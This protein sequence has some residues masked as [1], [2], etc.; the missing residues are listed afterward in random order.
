MLKYKD[1]ILG[2][3]IVFLFLLSSVLVIVKSP[4]A[5]ATNPEWLGPAIGLLS[6]NGPIAASS[7]NPAFGPDGSEAILAELDALATDPRVKAIVLRINSPGGTVGASQEL[8]ESVTAIRSTLKKPVIV[9]IADMGTSGAYW[10]SMAGS[11][12][13]ANPGSVVGS[14]GVIMQSMDFTEVPRRY[15]INNITYKSGKYKDMLSSWRPASTDEKKLI[16]S[17]LDDIHDQFI[18]TLIQRRGLSTA[19]AMVIAQG[20]VF[21]GRQALQ[22][23]LI[24]YVGSIDFAIALAAKEVGIKGKPPI[25]SKA[26][27][28]FGSFLTKLLQLTSMVNPLMT[29]PRVPQ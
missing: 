11:K 18:H 20:Q 2:G 4:P 16:Q 29:A 15:G 22:A 14:I 9:S 10:V 7:S 19:N 12:I 23:H 27:P 24:D 5:S 21:S 3:A 8:Y 1:W 25:V 13:V 28:S 17:V 26:Q 6:I